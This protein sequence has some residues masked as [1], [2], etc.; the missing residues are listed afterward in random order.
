VTLVSGN[1]LKAGTEAKLLFRAT[2]PGTI[3]NLIAA[4]DTDIPFLRNL[5]IPFG[6]FSGSIEREV[7]VTLPEHMPWRRQP[8]RV[9]LSV[10]SFRSVA[11]T[12]KVEIEISPLEQPDVRFAL[13]LKESVGSMNGI[14][15][16]SEQVAASI[17]VKNIG[18]G[19]ILDG[20]L[21]LINVNNSPELFISKGNEPLTLNPGE[22]KA[23][24]FS[25]KVGAVT[26]KSRIALA[27]SLY[28][29]KTKYSAG[30]SIPFGERDL[31]CRYEETGDRPIILATGTPLY[32][33]IHL[34]SPVAVLR[35]PATLRSTGRCGEAA[36][37]LQDGYWARSSDIPSTPPTNTGPLALDRRYDIAMPL[38]TLDRS[39]QTSTVPNGRLSFT[40]AGE[41]IQ[42]I[43]A[44]QNNRKVF[45]YRLNDG[46]TK[47]E[48]SVPLTFKEKTNKV[49]IVA[50]G[51]DR[52]RT[53]VATRYFYYPGGKE[54]SLS[55]DD[56][57]E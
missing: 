16:S 31:S 32:P 47:R 1:P 6:S 37:R 23:V 46:E 52:E 4:F 56:Q 53:G 10:D 45:Y 22:E 5:E 14:L 36:I 11:K 38:L 34:S 33:D 7:P 55:A 35:S 39:P 28:D 48:F 12:E 57:E 25:F 17:S 51:K 54:E 30:F 18:K 13:L 20:R 2:Y 8:V 40:V 27:V 24:V 43:F 29:Y 44:Y 3:D 41:E 49:M 19:A 50:K 15:E 9:D 26:A 42:D 21:Q